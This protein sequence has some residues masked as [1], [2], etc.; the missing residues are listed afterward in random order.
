[1]NPPSRRT[2]G[3]GK[4]MVTQ[5]HGKKE[6]QFAQDETRRGGEV[7]MFSILKKESVGK[8]ARKS[9]VRKGILWE[10]GY[11]PKGGSTGG[12]RG[13]MG[14]FQKGEQWRNLSLGGSHPMG[15]IF[16]KKGWGGISRENRAIQT[17]G[18]GPYGEFLGGKPTQKLL[19]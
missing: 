13:L 18:R 10:N 9:S 11:Q 15:I 19:F 1:L 16:Q 2:S 7:S 8:E 6:G 14:E 4:R 5:F 17:Q 12:G 3:G